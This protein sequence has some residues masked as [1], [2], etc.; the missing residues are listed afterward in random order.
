MEAE[1]A[2]GG[3]EAGATVAE[4]VKVLVDG[5]VLD[6]LFVGAELFDVEAIVGAGVDAG[7]GGPLGVEGRMEVQQRHDGGGL[8]D[9]ELDVVLGLDEHRVLSPAEIGERHQC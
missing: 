7:D 3:E 6:G 4:G 1:V 2:G 8:G 9:V 5:E